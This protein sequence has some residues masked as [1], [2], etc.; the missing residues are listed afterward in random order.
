MNKRGAKKIK[1]M[2]GIPETP[3]DYQSAMAKIIQS[4]HKLMTTHVAQG[5]CD[6]C[7][8]RDMC[9]YASNEEEY[10]GLT[11]NAAEILYNEAIKSPW[12]REED[13]LGMRNLAAL[14]G[15]V[16]FSEKF[17]Q[18]FGTLENSKGK[19]K[20]SVLFQDYLKVLKMYNDGLANFGMTPK[21]RYT[22]TGEKAKQRNLDSNTLLAQYVLSK[23]E[24]ILSIPVKEDHAKSTRPNQHSGVLQGSTV[25]QSTA[26]GY[27]RSY[28]PGDIPIG[29]DTES[30]G[31]VEIN[32]SGSDT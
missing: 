27:A 1:S 30:E 15:V 2:I 16:M 31:S 29:D 22:L 24:N 26:T 23:K 11:R 18:K 9:E 14:H 28:T 13:M 20:Y 21:G 12:I 17:F 5:N 10:C 7:V 25:D 8:L 19:V 32:D 4:N 6:L 3:S